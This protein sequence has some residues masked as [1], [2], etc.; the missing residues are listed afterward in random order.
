MAPSMAVFLGVL[1][2]QAV[3]LM[4]GGAE[5]LCLRNFA[6]N[7]L[8]RLVVAEV[9]EAELVGLVLWREQV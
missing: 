9:G 5:L 8:F 7:Q 1:G 4:V 6:P 2:A 3:V